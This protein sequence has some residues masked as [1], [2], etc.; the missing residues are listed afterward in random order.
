MKEKK[1]TTLSQISIYLQNKQIGEIRLIDKN[2]NKYKMINSPLPKIDT[3][4]LGKIRL[5]S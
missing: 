4:E 1:N 5:I 3:F 2:Y